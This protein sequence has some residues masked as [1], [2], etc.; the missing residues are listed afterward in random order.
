MASMERL[1]I[2]AASLDDDA[3]AAPARHCDN[4]E[5][6]RWRD[7]GACSKGCDRQQVKEQRRAHLHNL[8]PSICM[9][10]CALTS[11]RCPVPVPVALSMLGS[12]AGS[13]SFQMRESG[14]AFPLDASGNSRTITSE[15]GTQWI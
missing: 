15:Y 13:F 4:S 6:A 2:I 12:V 11:A 9:Y 3:A 8:P 14:H 5:M 10:L 7:R 1:D